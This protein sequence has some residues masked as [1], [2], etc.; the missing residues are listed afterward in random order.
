MK[1]IK[2]Q[3]AAFGKFKDFSF[4][5]NDGLNVVLENNGWGKSTFA[6]FLRDVFYGINSHT[7][8]LENDR[9]K[10]RPWGSVDLFG[11]SVDFDWNGKLFRIERFF[12][13]KESDDTVKLYNLENGKLNPNTDNL[14]ERIFK[15]DR[16]GFLS[17]LFFSQTDF[18]V[19]SGTGITKKYNDSFGDFDGEKFDKAVKKLDEKIKTYKKAGDHGLLA[20]VKLDIYKAKGKIETARGELNNYDLLKQRET[21]AQKKY[22][23]AKLKSEIAQKILQKASVK[24]AENARNARKVEIA[25]SI[26][27][28]KT[29]IKEL[30][31]VL[32]G[33]R[34]SAEEIESYVSL[35]E[36]LSKSAQ[37][38]KESEDDLK[39]KKAISEANKNQPSGFNTFILFAILGIIIALSGI[40]TIFFSAIV[41]AILLVIGGTI[42]AVSLV[43]KSKKPPVNPTQNSDNDLESLIAESKKNYAQSEKTLQAF[44][45][46]FA[47][48]YSN[49]YG[50]ALLEIKHSLSS[51]RKEES[52]LSRLETELRSLYGDEKSDETV[53]DKDIPSIDVANE[54]YNNCR[55]EEEMQRQELA[56]VRSDLLRYDGA[57]E[58]LADAENELAYLVEQEQAYKEEYDV[59]S[60]TKEFLINAN[61]N[62]KV[63]YK[64]PIEDKFREYLK[65]VTGTSPENTNIDVDF[66]VTVTEKGANRDSDFFSEGF[67]SVFNICK[68]F[69]LIDV[70]FGKDKPFIV[71]DDPFCDLDEDKITESLKVLKVLSTEFQILY[72]TCHKSR[73]Y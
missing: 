60:K 50:Y 61:E 30:D 11:G 7:R 6:A 20:E 13:A 31:K 44:L 19:K 33:K 14:G 73:S 3:I 67:K 28:V 10:Y 15:I 70:L 54:Y 40:A 66:K 63:E 24:S 27:R 21:A 51:V 71:L 58:N 48:S 29:N 8:S 2:C 46:G 68:R 43:L 47:V 39:I 12:G 22:E 36:T 37:K 23:E 25:D 57:A 32:L 16:D 52:E 5:F 62:L 65:K 4:D 49:G 45:S 34:P 9:L 69:A 1:L 38:I 18:S 35:S 41:G 64:K 72:L 42:S 59:L 53:F 26:N 17:T 56:K 55:A